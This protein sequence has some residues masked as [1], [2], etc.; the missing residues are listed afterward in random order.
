MASGATPLVV[1]VSFSVTPS[2][3][4]SLEGLLE[5]TGTLAGLSFPSS[6]TSEAVLALELVEPGV[7]MARG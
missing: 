5:E 2:Y 6:T 1:L 3:W 4:A 7:Q